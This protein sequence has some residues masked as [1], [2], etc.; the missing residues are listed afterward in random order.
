MQITPQ[1]AESEIARLGYYRLSGFWYPSRKFSRDARGQKITCPRTGKPLRLD[2]FQP[3]TRFD[4]TVQLYR[5]DKQLRLLMLDAI[6]TVEV[7]LKTVVAHELG[8]TDNMAYTSAAFIEPRWEE[9]KTGFAVSKWDAWQSRQQKKLD[10]C[11]EEC[12]AWHRLKNQ[13]IPFW[14]A[15]EAWDFGTLSMYFQ[16]LRRKPQGWILARLGIE[17]AKAFKSWLRELNTLRNR[18]AHHTRIWNQSSSNLISLPSDEPYF[19]GLALDSNARKRLYGLIAVLWFLL[20]RIEPGTTW[21]R[22]VADLINTKPR[23]PGC[24]F[25]SM[26]FSDEAGFPRALFG[27]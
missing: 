19:Q 12:I 2:D 20:Q 22:Q 1:Q 17:D 23:M 8:R 14:V 3:G 11:D 27:I 26:G 24:T 9:I 13:A 5:F 15:V 6:E 21:I 7:H 18:C 4:A 25:S 16:L 10:E